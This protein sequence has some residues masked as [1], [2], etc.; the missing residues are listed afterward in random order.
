MKLRNI[1]N[2]ER[3]NSKELYSDLSEKKGKNYYN[4]IVIRELFKRNG[5]QYN[6]KDV[7]QIVKDVMPMDLFHT[8]R[9]QIINTSLLVLRLLRFQEYCTKYASIHYAL[10]NTGTIVHKGGMTSVTNYGIQVDY[11]VIIEDGDDV[12]IIK[13]KNKKPDLTEGSRNVLHKT[14]ESMELFLLQL[15]AEKV[16][17][18]KRSYIAKI[19]FLRCDGDKD[20]SL[21]PTSRYAD[22]KN[23]VATSSFHLSHRGE[24][25]KRLDDIVA[26]QST[27]TCEDCSECAYQK[28]CMYKKDN[29]KNLIIPQQAK[30]SGNV[31]FTDSQKEVIYST[32]GIYRVLAGAGSGK[33][34]CIANRICYLLSVGLKPDDIL[35]ITF[36]NKGADEMREKI[37]YWLKVNNVQNINVK[38]LQI[39]TFNSYGFEL[40]KKEYAKF[41]YT[42]TPQLLEKSEKIALIKELLDAKPEIPGFNY[43]EPVLDMPYAKGVVLMMDNYFTQIKQGNL[44]YPDEVQAQCKIRDVNVATTILELYLEYREHMKQNNLVDYTDQVQLCYEILQDTAMVEKYGHKY[45]MVDEFQDSDN[46]QIRILQQMS[47]FSKFTSLMV[48][49]DDSQAIFSWRGATA[50]NIIHFK[51][52]FPTALD[53]PLM[54]NFRSTKEIC[55]LANELNDINKEKIPKR[56]ISDRSDSNPLMFHIKNHKEFVEKVIEAMVYYGYD[57]SDIALIAR[58]KKDLIEIQKEL[59]NR[60]VPNVMS[61][62]EYLIE[63]SVV[64]HLIDF[65]KYLLDPSATLSFAEYLQVADYANYSTQTKATLP[66]YVQN[67]IDLFEAELATCQDEDERIRFIFQKFEAIA[68]NERSV[69]SLLDVLQAKH[70]HTLNELAQFMI[71]METYK[72]EYSIEK[73]ENP[74]NAITLTTAHS[75]KGREWTFVAIYVP[76]FSYPTTL[77]YLAVKNNPTYEEER[78]L[79]FVA[80]TRAKSMLLIGGDS[81]SSAYKEIYESWKRAESKLKNN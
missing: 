79:L 65:A 24:M 15:A 2:N 48:V 41:G 37:A 26:G 1:V 71:D 68:Q 10:Q 67:E 11:S 46:L 25:M 49:G 62:S 39:F 16:V 28:L 32:M 33:T 73:L 19:A 9:E 35:L 59:V 27:H 56:L 40:V 20:D 17:P 43:K 21:L 80:I 52:V 74:V 14:S 69:R 30:A 12:T 47:K 57:F 61:V 78:R 34:T 72:A 75:S 64:Q 6:N 77:D 13:V 7:I 38:D 54:E 45:V 70:F 4:G 58:N 81:C 36:T 51:D 55:E 50:N 22:Y 8:S 31:T 29:T 53:I 76:S 60:N 66:K 23:I 3:C 18:N 5:L 63:N 44:T 42:S